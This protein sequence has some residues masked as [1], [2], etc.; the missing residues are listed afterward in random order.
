M[1]YFCCEELRRNA[2]EGSALNGID[3]LEVLDRDAAPPL[4]RQRTLFVRFVNALVAPLAAGNIRIEGGERIRNVQVTGSVLDASDAHILVVTVDQP[5]DFSIYTLRLVQDALHEQ[6]PPGFDPMLSAVHF[7]F[8][9]ECPSDFDCQPQRVCPPQ[10]NQAVDIDY[11]AKDYA[12]FRRLML[13][14]MAVLM[15]QWQERNPADM[16]IALV[17]LLA[18]AGDY[19]SYQ[20]DAV[21]TEAYLGTARRRVSVRRHARLVDYLMHDGCNARAW[22]HIEVSADIKKTV[23]T[24]PSPLPRG[25]PLLTRIAGQDIR[26]PNN[27]TLLRHA[28]VIFETMHDVDALF[29]AHNELPFYTWIDQS[30]CL[31]KGATHATLKG[32]FPNLQKDDVL[33]FEEVRGPLT[34]AE[35]DADPLH[36]HAVRLTEVR[37]S[38]VTSTPL[39][40]PLNAQEITEISWHAEDALPFPLCISS[41][42]TES[43][44]DTYI[45]NVSMA[46]GNIVLVDHGWTVSGELLDAVPASKLSYPATTGANR[47]EHTEQRLLPPRFRPTLQQGP[48]TQAATVAK[49]DAA[50]RRQIVLPFDPQAPASAAFDWKME[51][52]L[53]AIT[54]LKDSIGHEWKPRRDLLMSNGSAREFVA[55]TENDGT[56]F[57]RF[58]NDQNGLRPAEGTAFT[59][60]YRI[61]NGAAGNMGA[62]AIYHIATN[63]AAIVRVRNPLS[64]RGGTEPESIEDVRQRAPAAFRT[65]QRAVTP[66]DY[67]EVTQRLRRDVQRTATTFRWT[68]SWHTVFLTVDRPGGLPVDDRF[69]TKVRQHV[70]RYRMAGYDLEVDGPS[71]V[72]LEIEMFVCAKPEYF[73][74]HIKAALLQTFSNNTLPDGRRGVFHPDNFTFGQ[75]VY[76]SRIYA[77]AQAVPGVASVHITKFG[78]QGAPAAAFSQALQ[79]GKL[80]LGRLEIARLDNDRN[81]PERGVFRLTL[82]GGK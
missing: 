71:F 44:S 41:R 45:D 61:G 78:R 27:P 9:V 60:T 73:R 36:R 49:M 80:L 21:A 74:S 58:G 62:E 50:T 82:G 46:R 48:L 42:T 10:E 8:K 69:E 65:Q 40:D 57:L 35:A 14:R 53:P 29:V 2:V 4:E 23:P 37:H 66:A 68:G 56:T 34:G 77:A 52:V 12:S 79:D 75:T 6:P 33:I 47:C 70:E 1:I 19:L 25:T 18:F 51:Q 20:Q 24:A 72:S 32:H 11:L 26:L 43:S 64:A 63:D 7:S 67:S 17:E 22:V 31:P 3:F 16:G 81:F 15:P 54:Q 30:C 13:D 76:L 55:E 5:G 59:A 28:Q 39:T 38:D